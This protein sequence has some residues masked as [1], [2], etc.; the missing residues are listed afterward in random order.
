M[1]GS[2]TH[3]S[4]NPEETA[5]DKVDTVTPAVYIFCR[6]GRIELGK[7]PGPQLAFSRSLVLPFA[8]RT[9]D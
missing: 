9:Q 4:A 2:L 3:S 5:D 1:P 7:L 8:Y 6:T